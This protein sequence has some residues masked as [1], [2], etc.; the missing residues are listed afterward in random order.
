MERKGLSRRDFLKGTVAGA[1]TVA[2]LGLL[3]ACTDNSEPSPTPAV[4]TPA[5]GNTAELPRW[6]P[7][8]WDYEADVVVCGCGVA[9]VMGAREAAKQG[10]SCVILEKAT[11]ELAGGA[12]ACFGGFYVPS[13]AATLLSGANGN[14][15]E[16]E[17]EGIAA[18]TVDD[19][20]WMMYNGMTTNDFYKA[21]GAGAG[22]YKVLSMALE[23]M[24]TDVLYETA[25]KE[26]VF[27]PYT[28]EVY[29]V[30]AQNGGKEIFVKANKGVLLATG[31]V[32]GNQE[33]LRQLYVPTGVELLNGCTPDNTGDGLLM[34]M[35][36]GAALHNMTQHGVE[37]QPFSMKKASE[38]LG[39]AIQT[40][41]VGAERGAR[42]IVD[43][44]GTRFMNEETDLSHFKG[45][46]PWAEFPGAP[47]AGGYQGFIHKPFYM[48]FDEQLFNSERLAYLTDYGWAMSKGIYDWSADNQAELEKG[49]IAKGDTV[50]ELVAE[51]AKQSGNEPID[52]EGLKATLAAY[53]KTCEGGT[54]AFGRAVLK[55][56]NKG[57]YY[58]VELTGTLMYTIGGL[59]T[60]GVGE[61]LDWNGNH[62]AGLY[63]AGDIGQV[64]E[65]SP[66][67]ACGCGAMGALAV[68]AMLAAP[69]REVFGT[70][71]TVIGLPG[72]TATAVAV[73]GLYA[74]SG[75]DV[76]QGNGT[77]EV[78]NSIISDETYR[79]GT[80]TGV[81]NSVI[82]GEIEVT[83]TVSGGKVT[84]VKVERHSE[85]GT[86]GGI[87]MDTLTKQAVTGNTYE[88]DGVSGATETAKGFAEAVRKA[89][90]QAK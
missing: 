28:K 47:Q 39:T 57:S 71:E 54:D 53:N 69:E 8:K 30:K 10:H 77:T 43:S 19:F 52:A 29:G 86:I 79:D 22:F 13:Q 67:G 49:W 50:E 63:S 18:Q 42:I 76:Q 61:T 34:G 83:V 35:Q 5:Q 59:L 25:A 6:V 48:I 44:K 11:K 32:A 90:E 46:M 12:S 36:V 33:L 80:Y 3:S 62:I 64:V 41:P 73:G 21:D 1:A 60:N 38:E 20:T 75:E 51:L 24:G 66:I 23:T 2:S 84:D 82:G 88:V 9:G 4:P 78:T 40:F 70:A 68:R 16:S 7:A 89:L 72:E 58:A 55:P 65:T 17:A 74:L 87:A 85:T 45:I 15:T 37:L 26:L 31:S 27:D 14:I 56:I 81:G